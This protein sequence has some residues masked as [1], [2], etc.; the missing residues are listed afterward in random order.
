MNPSSELHPQSSSL[1]GQSGQTPL[2]EREILAETPN[3]WKLH[4]R[5]LL[6]AQVAL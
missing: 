6:L 2:T 1:L 3:L 5:M 4:L